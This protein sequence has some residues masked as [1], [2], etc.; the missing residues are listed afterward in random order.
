MSQ[1]AGEMTRREEVNHG[2]AETENLEQC[3]GIVCPEQIR[4]ICRQAGE[5]NTAPKQADG[6]G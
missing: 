4:K 3:T 1:K 2:T 5:D 6:H